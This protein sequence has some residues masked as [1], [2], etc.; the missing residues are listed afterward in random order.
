MRKFL[1]LFAVVVLL[2]ACSL[3]KK[4]LGMARVTPDD[5]YQSRKERLVIPPDYDV[6]PTEAAPE[7]K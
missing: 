4:D 2:S 3:T 6:R 1:V 7:A 5:G